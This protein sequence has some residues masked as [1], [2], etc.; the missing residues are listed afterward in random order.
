MSQHPAN[1]TLRFFLELAALIAVGQWGWNLSSSLPLRL[2]LALGLPALMAAAWV[3]FGVP[4]DRPNGKAPV[5]VPGMVR[6]LLE[7]VFFA[8]PIWALIS[9][10]RVVPG[11]AFAAAVVLH[12]L[13]S[14]D[15]ITWL[16]R[17]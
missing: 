13:L 14:L 11:A 9:T 1:L 15:R 7:L 17:Q 12:Y 8:F 3:T 16:S 10:G 5:P 2:L 4:A 6:L